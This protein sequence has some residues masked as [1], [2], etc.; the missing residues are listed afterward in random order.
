MRAPVRSQLRCR[1]VAQ[2]TSRR[3]QHAVTVRLRSNLGA[4]VRTRVGYRLRHRPDQKAE[5]VLFEDYLGCRRSQEMKILRDTL[6]RRSGGCCY[7]VSH[8]RIRTVRKCTDDF[9]LGFN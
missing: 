8:R 6:L 4:T 7:W 5:A 2:P 1:T 3:L 9:Y